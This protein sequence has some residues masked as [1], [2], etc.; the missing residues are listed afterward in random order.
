MHGQVWA[1]QHPEAVADNALAGA[2]REHDWPITDSQC[3][4]SVPI[5]SEAHPGWL[6]SH[7]LPSRYVQGECLQQL[8]DSSLEVC[9][10]QPDEVLTPAM[11]ADTSASAKPLY[12]QSVDA[13]KQVPVPHSLLSINTFS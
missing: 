9:A 8:A 7:A 13:Y 4:Q 2:S 1:S 10:A 5:L 3:M 11:E 6:P 12:A